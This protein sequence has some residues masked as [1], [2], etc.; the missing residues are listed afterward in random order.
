M[1]LTEKTLHRGTVV[2]MKLETRETLAVFVGTFVVGY[3]LYSI[4]NLSN[5]PLFLSTMGITI[6]IILLYHIRKNKKE[7]KNE[8]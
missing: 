1:E 8:N 7:I 2:K 5:I 6:P 4:F 3:A